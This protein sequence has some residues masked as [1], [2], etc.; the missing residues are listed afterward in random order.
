MSGLDD[1]GGRLL[2]FFVAVAFSA[3]RSRLET[4]FPRPSKPE[5]DELLLIE[6]GAARLRSLAEREPDADGGRENGLSTGLA[7]FVNN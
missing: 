6:R 3:A 4:P 1:L 7:S 2:S 5:H